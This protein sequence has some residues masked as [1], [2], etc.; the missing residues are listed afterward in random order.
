MTIICVQEYESFAIIIMWCNSITNAFHIVY[1]IMLQLSLWPVFKPFWVIL[2]LFVFKVTTG[3]RIIWYQVELVY[4]LENDSLVFIIH[5]HK[6]ITLNQHVTLKQFQMK[7]IFTDHNFIPKS[8]LVKQPVGCKVQ[9]ITL[10]MRSS[11]MEILSFYTSNQS[12]I[13][14]NSHIQW[15]CVFCC[16]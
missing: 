8:P 16:R 4:R 5:N 1:F 12:Y 14:C 15:C 7:P 2:F 9:G 6:W 11:T 13:S 10:A 3:I